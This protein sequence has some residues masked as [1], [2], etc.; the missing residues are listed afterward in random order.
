MILTP[1]PIQLQH[2]RPNPSN[3]RLHLPLRRFIGATQH[4][5]HP[6]LR[7]PLAIQ[8][9]RR[10]KRPHLHPHKRRRHHVLRQPLHHV[11]AQ[12]LKPRHRI[13]NSEIRHQPL[14]PN[15][16]RHLAQCRMRRQPRLNLPQLQPHPTQL[17]LKVIAPQKLQ[18]PV[19]QIPHQIPRA[20]QPIPRHKRA[21]DKPLRRH[22]LQPQIPASHAHPADMQ[23]PTAP[24]RHRPIMLIQ[25]V[26]PGI[27]D[28]PPNRQLQPRHRR[29]RLQ[30]PGT[31]VHR[32][33]GRSVDVM[34][35]HF[36]QPRLNPTGQGL[37]QLPT[38]A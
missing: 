23:L 16:R 24:Q 6:R 25:Y 18:V 8:L 36:G 14:I 34:Q 22:L 11:T 35:A 33:L 38:T 15:Q 10:I 31:A 2:L 21:I 5:L 19:R 7:Q 13:T 32:R 1:H 30:R 27:T 9:P 3:H 4:R 29:T 12:R 26:K 20:I 28:G 17:H 37:C